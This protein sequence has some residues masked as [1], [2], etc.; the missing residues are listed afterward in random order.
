MPLLARQ[1]SLTAPK[2]VKFLLLWMA[3]LLLLIK[4]EPI[5]KRQPA[6]CRIIWNSIE[7]RAACFL[8][9]VEMLLLII[10]SQSLL[11]GHIRLI[12]SNKRTLQPPNFYDSVPSFIPMLFPKRLLLKVLLNLVQSCILLLSILLNSMILLE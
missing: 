10:Q 4:P 7:S 9:D 11:H 2:L 3:F 6:V 8:N 1:R 12:E 5:L